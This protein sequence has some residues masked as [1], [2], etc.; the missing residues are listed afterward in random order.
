MGVRFDMRVRAVNSHGLGQP[1]ATLRVA[2]LF[3]P[4]A[5]LSPVVGSDI[6]ASSRNIGAISIRCL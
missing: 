2:T 1:T 4:S 5:P 6:G 3:V